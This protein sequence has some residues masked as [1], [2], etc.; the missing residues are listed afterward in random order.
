MNQGYTY[1]I[2]NVFKVNLGLDDVHER[3]D[4]SCA[5]P[6]LPPCLTSLGTHISLDKWKKE[7]MRNKNVKQSKD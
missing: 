6:Q 5:L 3:I 7:K 1:L 2:V 4:Q